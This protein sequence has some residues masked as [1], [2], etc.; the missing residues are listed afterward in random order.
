[1]RWSTLVA[2]FMLVACASPG[3]APLPD[4]EHPLVPTPDEPFRRQPPAVGA[5][6]SFA[7]GVVERAELP[8]GMTLMVASRP[9]RFAT[10][11][12]VSRAAGVDDRPAVAGYVRLTT[13]LMIVGSAAE[14]LGASTG[15]QPDQTRICLSLRADRLAGGIA[16]LATAVRRPSFEDNAA[17]RARDRWLARID[18]GTEARREAQR[19]LLGAGRALGMRGSAVKLALSRFDRVRAVVT[20]AR[21]YAPEASALV[22]AGAADLASVRAAA[23]KAFG[24][25]PRGPESR[26]AVP[27]S[28]PAPR[29]AD[30]VMHVE[31]RFQASMAIAFAAPSRID[32]DRAAFAV[33]ERIFGRMFSSRL[34]LAIREGEGHSYGAYASYAPLAHDGLLTVTTAVAHPKAVAVATLILAE[35]ERMQRFE[36][37]ASELEAAKG[38]LREEMRADLERTPTLAGELAELFVA[39]WGPEA[40]AVLDR[41][42]AAVTG[43]DVQ[44]V[45]Q[46][47][48]PHRSPLVVVATVPVLEAFAASGLDVG[49]GPDARR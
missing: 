18:S 4:P 49:Y 38:T 36:P 40:W 5:L 3:R 34:N 19:W 44:R 30:V 6:D 47:Y 17:E 43:P 32:P 31:P 24:D 26:P 8:N 46:R 2:L 29:P 22:V 45:A 12:Y 20:H 42:V 33:L 11:C 37:S 9:S 41:R 1:M 39:G 28:A 35:I 27:K 7:P 16:A 21:A 25:W 10:V 48:L 15:H 14:Q 23:S 13:E